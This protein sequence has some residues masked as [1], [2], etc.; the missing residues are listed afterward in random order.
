MIQYSSKNYK[1]FVR[2]NVPHTLWEKFGIFGYS[3]CYLTTIADPWYFWKGSCTS[4]AHKP[5]TLSGNATFTK[6]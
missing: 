2:K 4:K 6:V 5:V 3:D 1:G